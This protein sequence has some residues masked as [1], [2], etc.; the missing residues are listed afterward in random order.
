MVRGHGRDG[1]VL[2][3]RDAEGGEDLPQVATAPG[4]EPVAEATARRERHVQVRAGLG[5]LG[6]G[7]QPG[8]PAADHDHGPPGLQ[9]RQA[10]AQPERARPTGDL[11]G[12]LH[13]TGDVLRVPGAAEG[14]DEGVVRQFTG[15]VRTGDGD[16]LAVGV[17]AGDP[18][19][20]HVDPG[21][22][23]HLVERPGPEV[24]ADGELVHPDP[25]DE[26]GFGVDEG[27]G[28]VLAAQSPGKATGGDGS[29]VSGAQ[30]DDAVPR[31]VLHDVLPCLRPLRASPAGL[32]P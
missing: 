14:V 17:H 15:A 9:P 8:E 25:F 12:V 22:R 20:P 21:V 23:E 32:A 30:D 27:D 6:R 18:R 16:G 26:V 19:D 2:V 10:F 3:R 5:D 29:G 28:R 1:G 4:G 31:G 11:V 7:L 24:L 13:D